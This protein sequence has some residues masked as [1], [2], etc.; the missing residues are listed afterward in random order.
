MQFFAVSNY[1]RKCSFV[2][3]TKWDFVKIVTDKKDAKKKAQ[4][5]P[6]V[7][8][9]LE[10]EYVKDGDCVTLSCRVLCESDF[11]IIWLHNNKEIKAGE[12]FEYITEANIYSLRIKEIFPEDSGVY[13]FEAHNDAGESY[14]SCSIIVLIPDQDLKVPV[15]KTF[16]RSLTV[17]DGDVALFEVETEQDILQLIWIKDGKSI[18]ESVSK[19]DFQKDA[20]KYSLKIQHC[21]HTQDFAQY[22]AK[23]I[24]SKGESVCSFYLNVAQK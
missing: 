16:P 12:D 19:Y 2:T 11:N 14:S 8:N 1:N 4:Q 15:F 7:V 3:I 22:Q 13:T 6:K 18:T 20:N 10:S 24:G 21:N 9:H 17:Q 5:A 23:A